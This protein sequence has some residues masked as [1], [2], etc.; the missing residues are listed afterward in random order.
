MHNLA[1][2]PAYTKVA[3]EYAQKMLNWRLSHADRTLTG[4]HLTSRGVVS[5]R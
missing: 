2:E 5:R 3:L 1:G 4:M